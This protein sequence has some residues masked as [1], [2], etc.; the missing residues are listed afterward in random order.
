MSR[1]AAGRRWPAPR[2]W[3]S[4]IA[5]LDGLAYRHH[6]LSHIQRLAQ[7]LDGPEHQRDVVEV[8]SLPKND[9]RN[10]AA[11]TFAENRDAPHLVAH[12]VEVSDDKRGRARYR[13]EGVTPGRH[14]DR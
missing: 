14:Q 6:Q 11:P 3:F 8:R 9:K 10:R 12:V 5:G 4:W 13:D 2:T 1:P 7:R